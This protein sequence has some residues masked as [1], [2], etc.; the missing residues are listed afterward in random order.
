MT[1][2]KHTQRKQSNK[3]NPI[4]DCNYNLEPILDTQSFRRSLLANFGHL[5]PDT[6]E[7]GRFSK[8]RLKERIDLTSETV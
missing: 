6:F 4:A 5:F 7:C 3:L 2:P 1:L 8:P